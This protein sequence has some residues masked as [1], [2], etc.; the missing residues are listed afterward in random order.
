MTLWIFSFLTLDVYFLFQSTIFYSTI[1]VSPPSCWCC[2]VYV[3]FYPLHNSVLSTHVRFQWF[4]QYHSLNIR[5]AYDGTPSGMVGMVPYHTTILMCM[6]RVPP[7]LLYTHIVVWIQLH[8]LSYFFLRTHS[9]FPHFHHN[10]ILMMM[11]ETIIML[12]W[13]TR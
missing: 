10:N 1:Y 3:P 11:Y 12:S 4:T 9:S 7:L 2:T 5:Y 6:V 8:L 13:A